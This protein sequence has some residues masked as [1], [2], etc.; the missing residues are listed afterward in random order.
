MTGSVRDFPVTERRRELPFE[1]DE[2]VPEGPCDPPRQHEPVED[3]ARL[4][5]DDE[6]VHE[7]TRVGL[8]VAL[9]EGVRQAG[10]RRRVSHEAVGLERRDRHRQQ[11]LPSEEA[12]H[13]THRVPDRPPARALLEPHVPRPERRPVR[14]VGDEREAALDRKA[15]A[16]RR[17]DALHRR[18]PSFRYRVGVGRRRLR[19][20]VVAGGAPSWAEVGHTAVP[21]EEIPRHD[22]VASPSWSGC[23]TR[24]VARSSAMWRATRSPSRAAPATSMEANECRNG[25]PAK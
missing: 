8:E 13:E 9:V 19:A 7:P 5:L 23:V 17:L 11:T 22:A 6:P 4:V 2:G 15:E 21:D 16:V 12:C 1:G 18:D 14:R 25:I 10:L 3:A 20:S 24:S